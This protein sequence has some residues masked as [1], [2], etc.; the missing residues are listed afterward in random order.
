MKINK[1]LVL[2]FLLTVNLTP[3]AFSQV[4]KAKPVILNNISI[5]A[6]GGFEIDSAYL[7]Y[8]DG[9]PVLTGNITQLDRK[10]VMWII[11]KKG[12]K[13]MNGKI[14]IGASESILSDKAVVILENLQLFPAGSD[15]GT[16]E[17]GRYVSLNAVITKLDDAIPYFTAKFKV[18]D[19]NGTGKISGSYIFAVKE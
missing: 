16:L 4:T 1:T 17:D 15:E 13:D 12:W 8:E 7:N 11:I 5:I 10:I 6:T 18:W 3:A 9:T 19:K 14:N 2:L